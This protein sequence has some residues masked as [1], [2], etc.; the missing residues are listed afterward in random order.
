MGAQLGWGPTLGSGTPEML[1]QPRAAISQGGKINQL[2]VYLERAGRGPPESRVWA[3][4][5][6]ADA[7]DRYCTP[8]KITLH[9]L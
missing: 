8:E 2:S 4:P 3:S 9:L 6:H 1:V 7:D 5:N